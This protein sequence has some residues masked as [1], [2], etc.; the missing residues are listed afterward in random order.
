M[1]DLH[2]CFQLLIGRRLSKS[3]LDPCLRHGLDAT[4]R[5]RVWG[6]FDAECVA[7][8]LGC[9]GD[10]GQSGVD[11]LHVLEQWD[12]L[13][14]LGVRVIDKAT[15]SGN[16]DWQYFLGKA[17]LDV[18]TAE[19]VVF[20]T[21]RDLQKILKGIEKFIMCQS[22]QWCGSDVRTPVLIDQTFT[23]PGLK[24]LPFF[25]RQGRFTFGGH[26]TLFDDTFDGHPLR[27]FILRN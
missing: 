9:P 25:F 1:V 21:H 24:Y 19:D 27:D 12:R 18:D 4:G 16:F 6:G 5:T 11:A 17:S 15:F 26:P 20:C 13:L 3:P 8:V 10:L 2:G 14:T 23:K 7:E 22:S